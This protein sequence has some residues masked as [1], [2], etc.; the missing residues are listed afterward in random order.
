[1]QL[2][3]FDPIALQAIA[4]NDKEISLLTQVLV[5]DQNGGGGSAEFP[6][7][8]PVSSVAEFKTTPAVHAGYAVTWYGLSAAGFY[9]TRKLISRGRA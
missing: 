2:F 6:L 1:M 4:E 9:M 8:P 3:W 7:K 5:K